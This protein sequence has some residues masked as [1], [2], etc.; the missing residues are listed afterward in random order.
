MYFSNYQLSTREKRA[1]FDAILSS[2]R[3]FHGLH[4]NFKP[5]DSIPGLVNIREKQTINLTDYEIVLV[6]FDGEDSLLLE[7]A[8]DAL[9]ELLYR[10]ISAK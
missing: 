4:L 10:K 9:I 5:K 3:N 8:S 2:V 6:D 7:N 1:K